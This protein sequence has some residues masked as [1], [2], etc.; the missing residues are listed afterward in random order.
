ME[1]VVGRGIDLDAVPTGGLQT[2]G[3][4]REPVDYLLDLT[5]GERAGGLFIVDVERRGV[6][7]CR[8]RHRLRHECVDTAPGSAMIKLREDRAPVLV[9]LGR[10]FLEL[11]QVLVV[12]DA[13]AAVSLVEQRPFHGRSLGDDETGSAPGHSTVEAL[14]DGAH[15]V[16]AGL[17]EVGLGRR[18]DDAV[19]QLHP[20]DVE[21]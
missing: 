7:D 17:E 18:L 14:G 19:L 4:R 20:A 6:G 8:R 3:P 10:E 2:G 15:A 9:N 11:F 13:E 12:V 21:R 16:L 5:D 1:Q